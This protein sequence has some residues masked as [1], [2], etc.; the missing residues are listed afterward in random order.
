MICLLSHWGGKGQ[1]QQ[2]WAPHSEE[3]FAELIGKDFTWMA[4]VLIVAWIIETC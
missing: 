3:A 2:F 1:S 4:T